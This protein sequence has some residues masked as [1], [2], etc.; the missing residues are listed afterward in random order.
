MNSIVTVN[1]LNK[2]C[3]SQF[4]TRDW[5]I[6]AQHWYPVARVEDV[7]IKPQ[8]VRLVDVKWHCIKPNKAIFI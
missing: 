2:P 6:L 8:Q 3:Y 4:E 5:E 1:L 7:S